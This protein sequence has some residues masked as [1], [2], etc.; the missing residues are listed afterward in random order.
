MLVLAMQFSRG[1]VIDMTAGSK[2]TEGAAKPP[3]ESGE[4][5][6]HSFRAEQRTER[7]AEPTT[8]RMN[9]RLEG[10]SDDPTS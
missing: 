1:P 5:S 2:P 10:D 3:P 9:L 7:S 8:R 4:G 6:G